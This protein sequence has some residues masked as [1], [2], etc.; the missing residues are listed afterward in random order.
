MKK[1]IIFILAIVIS[2]A[3]EAIPKNN[4]P[5]ATKA[6]TGKHHTKKCKRV[7]KFDLIDCAT[8]WN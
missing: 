5:F 7:K 1:L 3:V 4:L 2:V 6:K 8:F